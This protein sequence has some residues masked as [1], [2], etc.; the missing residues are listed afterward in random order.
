MI[1]PNS[2]PQFKIHGKKRRDKK[3][4]LAR[5]RSLINNW[6]WCHSLDKDMGMIY[7]YETISDERSE[8]KLKSLIKQA[9]FL[10]AQLAVPYGG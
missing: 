10:E 7:G 1:D 6:A 4:K 5:L 3:K 2:P 9:K 8:K